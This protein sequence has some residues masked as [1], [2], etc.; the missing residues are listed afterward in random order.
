MTLKSSQR[1]FPVKQIIGASQNKK[2]AH[3]EFTMCKKRKVEPILF[4]EWDATSFILGPSRWYSSSAKHAK[5][6]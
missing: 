2:Y 1:Y 4:C 5:C 6:A 3:Y